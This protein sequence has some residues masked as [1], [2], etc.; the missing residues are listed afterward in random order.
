MRF[1]HLVNS[2]SGRQRGGRPS[3][4]HRPALGPQGPRRTRRVLASKGLQDPEAR[5]AFSRSHSRIP[6]GRSFPSGQPWWARAVHDAARGTVTREPRDHA[7]TSV[8]PERWTALVRQGHGRMMCWCSVNSGDLDVGLDGSTDLTTHIKA[9]T[10]D[11]RQI[12]ASGKRR[13]QSL[14]PSN[15]RSGAGGSRDLMLQGN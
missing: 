14:E 6:A 7:V 3:L 15:H 5:C 11:C 13:P 12:P 10:R 2:I 8:F 1:A 9:V 4:R